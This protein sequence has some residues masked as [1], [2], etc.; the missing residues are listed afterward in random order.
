MLSRYGMADSKPVSTPMTPG[1]CLSREQSPRTAEECA[2]MQSVDYGGAICYD[3]S[4]LPLHLA[5]LLTHFYPFTLLR[6]VLPEHLQSKH[7]FFTTR[8][9]WSHY[10][11]P[12]ISFTDVFSCSC[13]ISYTVLFP[14][15]ALA[16]FLLYLS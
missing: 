6:T 7:S 14:S 3:C 11:I 15:I 16:S 13:V 5:H 8:Y 12:I 1:L 4:F 10:P 9:A 2:F